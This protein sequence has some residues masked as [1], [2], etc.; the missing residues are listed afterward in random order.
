MDYFNIHK[1]INQLQ[2]LSLSYDGRW[3]GGGGA[4]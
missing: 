2:P 1:N 4:H 3:E